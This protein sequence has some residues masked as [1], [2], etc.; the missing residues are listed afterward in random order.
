[1]SFI[2]CS[3]EPSYFAL[4]FFSSSNL[5]AGGFGKIERLWLTQGNGQAII[6]GQDEMKSASLKEEFASLKYLEIEVWR[7]KVNLTDAQ[8]KQKLRDA[9]GLPDLIIVGRDRVEDG[10]VAA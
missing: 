2:L 3:F 10:P 1:M 4:R 7:M 6:E 8:A 9:F 5:P